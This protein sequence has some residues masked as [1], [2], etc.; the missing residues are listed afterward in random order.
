M[1]FSSLSYIFALVV[2]D[3]VTSVRIDRDFPQTVCVSSCFAVHVAFLYQWPSEILMKHK[4]F[5]T[6]L[7]SLSAT[8]SA[9]AVYIVNCT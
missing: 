7:D 6:L 4:H 5:F 1:L 3:I 9:H 8:T 2:H